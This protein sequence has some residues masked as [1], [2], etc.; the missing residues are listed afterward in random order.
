MVQTHKQTHRHTTGT[1]AKQDGM[2]MPA[3]PGSFM[4]QSFTSS[5]NQQSAVSLSGLTRRPTMAVS[6]EDGISCEDCAGI[7]SA[8]LGTGSRAGDRFHQPFPP[9]N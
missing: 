9:R 6:A 8:W 7:G 4:V 3:A 5:A 2:V 1:P